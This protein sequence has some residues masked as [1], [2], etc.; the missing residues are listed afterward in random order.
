MTPRGAPVHRL[1]PPGR[2][3]EPCDRLH[4]EQG[5]AI[6]FHSGSTLASISH[7][8][9]SLLLPTRAV[10]SKPSVAET[11]L[12]CAFWLHHLTFRQWARASGRGIVRIH[13]LRGASAPNNF[14][15]NFYTWIRTLRTIYF[16][17]SL[18]IRSQVRTD[19]WLRKWNYFP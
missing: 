2:F 8:I 15:V 11:V 1:S 5:S 6:Y 7:V 9:F 13:L 17:M 10:Q 19:W 4:V 18:K 14:Y 12:T 16:S 3:T